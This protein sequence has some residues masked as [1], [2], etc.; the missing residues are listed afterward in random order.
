MLNLAHGFAERGFKVDLVLA[1]A[2]GPYLAQVQTN[3]AVVDLASNRTLASLPRL[4]RYLSQAKPEA[5]LAALEHSNIVALWAKRLARSPV[6]V[7]VSEHLS[8]S[9]SRSSSLAGRAFSLLTRWFYPWAVSV[10]AVSEGV[11]DTVAQVTGFPRERLTVI[12]NPVITAELLAKI[13]EPLDHPWFAPGEP[14]VIL[15]VGRLTAQ[16]DFGMLLRAFS[17][18]RRQRPA[19]LLILGEGED[20]PKLE[21]LVS[22][23][24]LTLGE[25]VGLPGFVANPYAYMARAA[26]FALSSGWE[27]L[28]TVLI[29][30]LAA[31]AVVVSTDCDSGPR[32]ILANGRFGRLVPVGDAEAFAQAL[33]EALAQPATTSDFQEVADRYSHET[34]VSR[35]LQALNA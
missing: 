17:Q 10:V 14:P 22:E 5:L 8:L 4:V 26:V 16:K 15:A 11:A 25:D 9:P 27:G 24:G 3:V 18:V 20:R 34:A 12:Y 35:Y 7:L 31:G 33:L 23:Q 2:E 13:K 19:R 32:E 29:E 1:K 21:R 6:K 30:A 28:P